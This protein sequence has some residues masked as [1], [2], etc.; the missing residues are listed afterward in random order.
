MSGDIL[1][2]EP[3]NKEVPNKKTLLSFTKFYYQNKKNELCLEIEEGPNTF[4]KRISNQSENSSEVTPIQNG[5]SISSSEK[6]NNSPVSSQT[7][8]KKL[9]ET[10]ISFKLYCSKTNEFQQLKNILSFI[11]GVEPRR[12]RVYVRDI[13]GY[14]EG[15][16][17]KDLQSS[18]EN[19]L[20]KYKRTYTS[21]YVE[22][23]DHPE[24]LKRGDKL[25]KIKYYNI[26][27]EFTSTLEIKI[28][29][30]ETIRDMKLKLKE[31]TEVHEDH[32]IISEW[33]TEH[34]FKLFLKNDLKISDSHIRKSDIIRMDALKDS[35]LVHLTFDF[36]FFFFNFLKI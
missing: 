27:H 13:T 30:V 16:L 4:K 8:Q 33:H 35:A 12:L 1:H 23:I 31:K 2:V 6:D 7:S 26:H 24:D 29:K 32:Q 15:R 5:D 25:F 28:N 17:L 3:I 9:Q 14:S 20:T 21:L 11:F 10:K 22:I 19:I 34:F 18:L 36:I